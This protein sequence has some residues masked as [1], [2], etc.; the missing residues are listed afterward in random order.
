MVC[1]LTKREIYTAVIFGD[2]QFYRISF[3]SKNGKVK[4]CKVIDH[5]LTCIDGICYDSKRNV[6]YIADSEKNAIRV[7]DI[8]NNKMSTFSRK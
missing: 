2:G 8:A 7:W 6:I 4:E 5:S 1:V 3:E